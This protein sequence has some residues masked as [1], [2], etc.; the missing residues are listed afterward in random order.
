MLSNFIARGVNS[1]SKLVQHGLRALLPQ[2]CQL[3]AAPS[4]SALLCRACAQALPHLTSA[5]CPTC[6]LPLSDG[7]GCGRCLSQPPA[8]DATIAAFVYAYP[9]DDLIGGL[10]YRGRL[11]LAEWASDA[12]CAALA[13]RTCPDLVLAMPLTAMRQRER[14]YNQAFEIARLVARRKQLAL[15][16]RGAVRVKDGPPQAS[17]PWK[18]RAQN[19]RGAFACR[20]DLHGKSVAVIDD[21]MTTGASL[22]ELASTLKRAGA[23]S[24]ENWVVARTL[25]PN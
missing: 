22:D 17:L 25:P 12:L 8:Y 7:R 4:R 11:A 14:G 13:G 18:E 24:V 21:V 10:K 16:R 3:C 9:V 20:V 23:S 15:G 19:I 1:S 6:A 2:S 5:R